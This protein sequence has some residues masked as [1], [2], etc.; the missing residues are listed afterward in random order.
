MSEKI[1]EAE[2]ARRIA[3]A[4]RGDRQPPQTTIGFGHSRGPPF[5]EAPVYNIAEFCTAH[6]ISRSSLYCL[7]ADGL[8]PKFFKVGTSVRISREAAAAWRAERET[9]T[10]QRVAPDGK[11]A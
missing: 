8:G 3:E 5:E 7:W 2:L 9:A 4:L 11:A 6:R 10:N 1:R